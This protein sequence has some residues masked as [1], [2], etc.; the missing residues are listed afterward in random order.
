MDPEADPRPAP[1]ER[2]LDE[3]CCG[4]G[5]SPCV[6]DCY[7]EALARYEQALL[8]WKRRHPEG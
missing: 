2:P 1:P 4:R 7:E 8:E 6:F 3:A 5:C